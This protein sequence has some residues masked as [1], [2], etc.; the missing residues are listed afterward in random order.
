MAMN[1]SRRKMVPMASE[2]RTFAQ[3]E[4]CT[5]NID[6]CCNYNTETTVL[7]HYRPGFF[8]LAMKPQDILGAHL[9]SACHDILDGRNKCHDL[10]SVDESIIWHSAIVK[11]LQRITKR[12]EVKVVR[13]KK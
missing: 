8:G 4:E 11:T 10:T 12:Y 2:L 5:A 1:G 3:G 13:L 7:A 9:C 6:G